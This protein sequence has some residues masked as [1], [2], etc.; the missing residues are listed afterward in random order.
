M[1]KWHI[2]QVRIFSI[3]DTYDGYICLTYFDKINDALAKKA[4]ED[5]L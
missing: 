2:I 5:D 3:P 4:K 1:L